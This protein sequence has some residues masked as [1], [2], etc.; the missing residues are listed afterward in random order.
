VTIA[1][2]AALVLVLTVFLYSQDIYR[3]LH[4]V[5]FVSTSLQAER[6]RHQGI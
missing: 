4:D 2:V 1:G 6:K 5:G 3:G